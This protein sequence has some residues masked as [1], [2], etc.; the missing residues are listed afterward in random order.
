MTCST[1]ATPRPPSRARSTAAPRCATRTAIL[2]IRSLGLESR[3]ASERASL[4]GF[5][6]TFEALI[7]SGVL[8]ANAAYQTQTLTPILA[9][10]ADA[11]FPGSPSV[12]DVTRDVFQT[13][14]LHTGES[15]RL[16]VTGTWAPTCAILHAEIPGPDS[17]FEPI[18]VADSETG[19]EGF[20][21][22]R[23]SDSF[24]SHSSTTTSDF[25]N[26]LGASLKLCYTHPLSAVSTQ[27]SGFSWE[28]CVHEDAD[29][30]W[31]TGSTGANGSNIRTSASF[32]AGIRLSN[33]PFP[34]APAGSLVAVLTP[35][36]HPDQVLDVRVVHRDDLIVAPSLLSGLGDQVDV[37]LAVN[38][39]GTCG[40]GNSPALQI[41]AVKSIPFGNA[42]KAVGGAMAS[43]LTAIEAQ[44]PQILG[45][46]ELG[47]EE[48]A[49]MRATAWNLVQQRLQASGLDLAGVPYDL[50]QLFDGFVERE[51]ASIAR[52]A[53]M[54]AIARQ[55]VQIQLTETAVE[56]DL[57]F[58]GD[59]NRLLLLV[60]RWR[61][62]DLSG[63]QLAQATD[64]LSEALSTDVAQVYELRDPGSFT[65]FGAQVQSGI[66]ALIDLDVTAS[67]E[68]S[69]TA[70]E[71]FAS[72]TSIAVTGA[73]FDPPEN[74][75][76]TL[77]VAIPRTVTLCDGAPC[78]YKDTWT[79]VSS[80]AAQAF[81]STAQ[82][83]PFSSSVTLTPSDLY[84]TRGTGRLDCGDVAPV[85][86]RMAVYLD[87]NASPIDLRTTFLDLSGAAAMSGAPVLF[88]LVG[89]VLSLDASDPAGVALSLPALNGNV[90]QVSDRFGPSTPELG[91]GA[92]LSPFTT[93]H[94]DMTPFQNGTPKTALAAATAVL[95]VFD[96]ERRVSTSD[97]QVPG[98]CTP[99]TP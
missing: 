87:T 16:H 85:I 12:G 64:A 67:Y 23:E 1:R 31:T 41:E 9:S 84:S 74:L 36:G 50:H 8:D 99:L 71:Q 34:M 33:T 6:V 32:S 17:D 61:L 88:P 28:A 54:H 3:E 52:R 26:D 21:L 60:P 45:Q 75:R 63:V 98:I 20:W 94:I 18:Q 68:S 25:R 83:A 39:L 79:S 48:A 37:R 57:A 69:L 4:A 15:L 13:I 82:A 97:V 10:A 76:R 66:D 95:L 70:L 14:S 53:Q 80:A 91:T 46:G 89:S 27:A 51:I 78:D 24:K 35:T 30:I 38:D 19:P 62:R 86:R 7:N 59:Q 2:A 55:R 43:T 72:A 65:G 96:V 93:F 92:G 81:W 90:T 77:V 56:H 29:W 47:A 11:H 5:Q 49:A 73:V 44:A 58:A 22:S 42:A 40:P